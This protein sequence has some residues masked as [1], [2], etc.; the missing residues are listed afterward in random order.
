S[1]T[2]ARS[3]RRRRPG[4]AARRAEMFDLS[5]RT[6]LVTGASGGIGRAIA[7]LLHARGASLVLAGT[8][9]EQL[10]AARD[11]LGARAVAIA[12]DLRAQDAAER[13]AATAETVDILVANAGISRRSPLEATTD[14]AWD[15]VVDVNLSAV[16]RLVRRFAAP[17]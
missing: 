2:T 11:A 5:G 15:E 8:R 3:T 12:A 17:M 16:F 10:E 6:A 7:E 13:L 14:S 9:L 4:C 1:A